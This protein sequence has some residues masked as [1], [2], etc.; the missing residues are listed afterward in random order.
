MTEPAKQIVASRPLRE[1]V[2]D[3]IRGMILRG[4]LGPGE[5]LSER[6][7]GQ[8]LQVSTTPVKE[9]LRTLQA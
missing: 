7:I 5:Q 1:Q 3:I 2:A 6:A 4:E 8:M 9:A